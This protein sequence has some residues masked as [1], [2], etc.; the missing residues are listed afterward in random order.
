MHLESISPS[1]LSIYLSLFLS[2][3]LSLSF[4]YRLLQYSVQVCFCAAQLIIDSRSLIGRKMVLYSWGL[5]L[6]LSLLLLPSSRFDSKDTGLNSGFG[7]LPVLPRFFRRAP[8]PVRRYPGVQLFCKGQLISRQ[9]QPRTS[10]LP[11]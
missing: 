3:F 2:L 9:A 8:G 11:R 4:C 7:H 10:F 1:C 6:S 5:S